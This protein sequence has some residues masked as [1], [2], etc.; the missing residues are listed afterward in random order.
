MSVNPIKLSVVIITLNEERNIGKCLDAAWQVADEI[1]VV[2]SFSTDRSR[3]ICEE[4]RA[5]FIENRFEG[6][7]SQKNYAIDQANF[8]YIL[9][10]DADEILSDKLI[11]SIN[12][13]KLNPLN[14]AYQLNR[15][16]F[17]VDKFIKHGHWFPDK[18]V[19]LF[20]KES[21]N[22]TNDSVHEIFELKSGVKAPVL[23]GV[24]YHYTFNSI[25]EHIRQANNFSEI[26]ANQLQDQAS[27]FLI[28]KTLFS[29]LWGFLYGYV[30]RLG[31]LDGWYGLV[32]AVISSTETF[33]KYAKAIVKLNSIGTTRCDVI[34]ISSMKT[35]RG[36]EQQVANLVLG[37]QKQGLLVYMIVKKN[38]S[39][40][41]FCQAN[42][43]A[44][45]AINFNN[46]FNVLSAI[47][48]KSISKRLQAKILHMHCS[49]SHTLSI[50]S[51]LFGNSAKLVLSR[52]VIFP[53]R[54]NFLSYKKFN[55]EGISKI[56]CVSESTKEV[57]QKTVKAIDKL[58][59]IYDGIDLKKFQNVKSM[60]LLNQFGFN[61]KKIVGNIS[62]IE[63]EKDY[64]T[65][66]NTAEKILKEKSNVHFLIVGSGSESGNIQNYIEKKELD[67]NISML[68]FR[69]DVPEILSIL[70]VFLMTSTMEGLGSTIL[71][72]F[73]S[74]VPVVAT[75]V[76]GIPE[77]VVNEQTGLLSNP[78][79][80]ESLSNNV[81]RILNDNSF[82]KKVADNAYKLVKSRF[83]TDTMVKLTGEVYTSIQN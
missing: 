48:I 57:M 83:S 26:G 69:T 76:G 67:S 28:I 32:I 45:S 56:I 77:I 51:K 40:M 12:K 50:F 16:S 75:N 46:G 47:R 30:I 58:D 27:I 82:G 68:G 80:L 63:S 36:G 4:K 42:S 43:I 10:L 54:P 31:F 19:R 71:D 81:L 18:K 62:A 38:S 74:K 29:P 23:K 60:N 22:W 70:D 55:Y 44:Y 39:L 79:D 35:W 8:D 52:R 20:H 11:N 59:V 13:I 5:I 34:H 6:Y 1:V 15:L 3:Q 7:G 2:D 33:L 73:A 25:F 21:G 9:S 78:K 24:L 61:G 41:R 72:A 64:F 66:V 37:Q 65:F 49:P 53:V 14:R 17:Y